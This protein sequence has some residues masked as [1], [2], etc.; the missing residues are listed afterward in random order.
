MSSF[1]VHFLKEVE[2]VEPDR[3]VGGEGLD[4]VWSRQVEVDKERSL[5][6]VTIGVH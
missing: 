3:V 2:V 6:W 1:E 4:I 5:C